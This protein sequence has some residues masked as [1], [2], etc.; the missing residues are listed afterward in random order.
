VVP[1]TIAAMTLGIVGQGD[2]DRQ[3][4]RNQSYNSA[5]N[6]FAALSIAG[7]S[8]LLGLRWIFLAPILFSV[9][10]AFMLWRIDPGTID[11]VRLAPPK[12][13]EVTQWTCVTWYAPRDY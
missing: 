12:A 5:G 9:P 4:G 6:A 1:T 11:T 13:R 7:I 10:A 3:F 8:W 2:F